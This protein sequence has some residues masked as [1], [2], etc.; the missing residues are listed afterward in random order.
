MSRHRWLAHERLTATSVASPTFKADVW[1]FGLLC[2]E[3]FT[4][5]DPYCTYQDFYL[6]VL[7]SQGKSPEHPGSA[8]V[9]LSSKMW[10]L[11]QSCWKVNPVARPDMLDIQRSMREILS[12]VERRPTPGPTVVAR[13]PSASPAQRESE[14]LLP[15][16]IP[17][18]IDEL[19]SVEPSCSSS[20]TLPPPIGGLQLALEP[21][22]TIPSLSLLGEL[23]AI[24][25]P[26]KG[27]HTSSL[28][29]LPPP[30]LQEDDYD[31]HSSG[32]PSTLS[33]GTMLS[34]GTSSLSTTMSP[35]ERILSS[36]P[37]GSPKAHTP[38]RN[39]KG[40]SVP[41]RVSPEDAELSE[42]DILNIFR[43]RWFLSRTNLLTNVISAQKAEDGKIS[44][45]EFTPQFCSHLVK[46]A[47]A[48]VPHPVNKVER[49]MFEFIL[50]LLNEEGDMA[51]FE[52]QKGQ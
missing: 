1:S 48:L 50:E 34:R 5:A 37:Q 6:P 32:I 29:F 21:S 35:P 40:G 3:V 11:M 17:P 31:S 14:L 47:V 22:T 13:H 44:W 19:P 15:T 9:G 45:V 25:A 7:L 46:C 24:E 42:F 28:K 18:R 38:S 33:T 51:F 30:T 27:S 39:L 8:A 36:P 12:R 2:L 10:E 52:L 43:H 49:V 4:D 16:L 41:K 23:D 20:E 26:R